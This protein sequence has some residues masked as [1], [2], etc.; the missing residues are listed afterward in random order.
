MDV[1]KRRSRLGNK[2]RESRRKILIV[3]TQRSGIRSSLETICRQHADLCATAGGTGLLTDIVRKDVS[4][5]PAKHTPIQFGRLKDFFISTMESEGHST[6]YVQVLKS[7]CGTAI[8]LFIGS[9]V[10]FAVTLSVNFLD[11]A[12]GVSFGISQRTKILGAAF[13]IHS[14][15]DAVKYLFAALHRVVY[16]QTCTVL[17]L[18]AIFLGDVYPL[19]PCF[20]WV[21]SWRT[22]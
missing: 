1:L 9:Q 20:H 12:L 10:D 3:A 7:Y 16:K 2:I 18:Q 6:R 15:D 21:L 22:Q 17:V 4:S 14:L 13:A 5:G 8:E 19:N 11:D